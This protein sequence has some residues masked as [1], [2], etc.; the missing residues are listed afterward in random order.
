MPPGQGTGCWGSFSRDNLGSHIN[1][2][3]IL[4]M[5][6]T[7]TQKG[8]QLTQSQSVAWSPEL[9]LWSHSV[10]AQ[11][12]RLLLGPGRMGEHSLQC[13]WPTP[14]AP[15]AGLQASGRVCWGW[16]PQVRCC[17][18]MVAQILPPSLEHP[19]PSNLGDGGAGGEAS[20]AWAR[21]PS[22]PCYWL[23]VGPGLSP[24]SSLGHSFC[25]SHEGVDVHPSQGYCRD[26]DAIRR[27]VGGLKEA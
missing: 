12:L 23:E 24:L 19:H 11:G 22:P 17:C 20:G 2:L 1:I 10:L 25:I 6:E 5:R 7:E 27:L 26:S 21:Y 18:S 13:P 9:Q 3:P 8:T 4:Q 14:P 15:A 16:W